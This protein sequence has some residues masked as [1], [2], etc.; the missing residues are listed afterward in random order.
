MLYQVTAETAV[1]NKNLKI[2][3][4]Q[5][6]LSQSGG[7]VIPTWVLLDNQFT[8]YVFSNRRLLKNIRKSDR[9]LAIFST[10]G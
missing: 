6:V 9:G 2:E 3:K 10:G 8:V 4:Y 5:H 1:T 7:H